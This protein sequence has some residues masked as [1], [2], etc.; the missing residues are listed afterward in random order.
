MHPE[1]VLRVDQA[2]VKGLFLLV[3][4]TKTKQK[5]FAWIPLGDK[6]TIHAVFQQMRTLSAMGSKN[7]FLFPAAARGRGRGIGRKNPIGDGAFRTQ[8]RR[9]LK[10]VCKVVTPKAFGLH[11]LRVGGSVHM[12]RIGIDPEV[13]RLLGG[14]ASLESSRRY[15]SLSAAEMMSVAVRGDQRTRR[16]GFIGNAQQRPAGAQRALLA[17]TTATASCTN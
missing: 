5:E 9:A 4:W 13:H 1:N 6:S 12:R 11:S 15:Q 14:W 2:T 10:Q 8:L 3:P 16:S 17:L 7:P